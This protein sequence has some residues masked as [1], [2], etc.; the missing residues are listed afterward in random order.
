MNKQR[1]YT[2]FEILWVLLWLVGTYGWIANL[3]KLVLSI[4]GDLSTMFVA[5]CVGVLFFPLGVI[6]GF[7]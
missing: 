1:G 7:F 2:L 4:G 3:V 6:L 5:R